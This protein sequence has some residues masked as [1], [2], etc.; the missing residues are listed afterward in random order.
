MKP[1]PRNDDSSLHEC[2]FWR[3]LGESFGMR[4]HV[5]M[6]SVK[7]DAMLGGY[8]HLV[9]HGPR[10]GRATRENFEASRQRGVE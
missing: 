1:P 3:C 2:P 5:A 7:G 9:D 6:L 4:S 8:R 10:H